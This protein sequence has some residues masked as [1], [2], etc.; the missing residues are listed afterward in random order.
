VFF[1][2]FFYFSFIFLSFLMNLQ[3]GDTL[4]N[5]FQTLR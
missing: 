1:L 3:A 2:F 5:V 4:I